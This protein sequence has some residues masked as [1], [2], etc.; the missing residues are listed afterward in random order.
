MRGQSPH[1][2]RYAR[3]GV[4]RGPDG[5]QLTGGMTTTGR[6]VIDALAGRLGHPIGKSSYL[7][8]SRN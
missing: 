1:S 6:T 8:Q 4:L 3:R 2:F 5:R 7:D